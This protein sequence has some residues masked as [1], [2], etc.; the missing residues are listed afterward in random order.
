MRWRTIGVLVVS[1]MLIYNWRGV[2]NPHY[3][4]NDMIKNEQKVIVLLYALD[5]HSK[6]NAVSAKTKSQH[7]LWI[8][9]V[10]FY[11]LFQTS[12]LLFFL[13]P[14][15]RLWRAWDKCISKLICGHQVLTQRYNFLTLSCQNHF[16]TWRRRLWG[17]VVKTWGLKWNSLL[18][19]SF[20]AWAA[21]FTDYFLKLLFFYWDSMG[22]QHYTWFRGTG[23]QLFW[24]IYHHTYL[25]PRQ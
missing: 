9:P 5:A 25:P 22:I 13:T 8:F 24:Y 11:F 20:D 12:N 16:K 23:S 4:D 14:T 1:G 6:H 2:V 18:L 10:L 19:I 7:H 21:S 3:S 15:M 17:L